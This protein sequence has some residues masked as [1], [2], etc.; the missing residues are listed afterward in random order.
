MKST[1][2][3]HYSSVGIHYIAV[4][5]M[6]TMLG[7]VTHCKKGTRDFEGMVEAGD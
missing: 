2:T 5:M 3:W 1:D 7:K 4:V 6:G